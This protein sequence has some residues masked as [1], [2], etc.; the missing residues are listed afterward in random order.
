[1]PLKKLIENI[2]LMGICF[3]FSHHFNLLFFESVILITS[4]ICFNSTRS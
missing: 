3:V 1:M 4:V 2:C